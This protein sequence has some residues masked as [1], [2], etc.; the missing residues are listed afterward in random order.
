MN[1]L[2]RACLTSDQKRWLDADLRVRVAVL[3]DLARFVNAMI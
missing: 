1:R 2:S 3:E